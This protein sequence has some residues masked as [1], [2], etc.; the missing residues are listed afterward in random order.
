MTT[1]ATADQLPPL[2]EPLEII[3]PTLHKQALG[4][5]VEDRGIRDRYE[6]AEYGWQDG[7]DKVAECLPNEIYDADQMNAYALASLAASQAEIAMLRE[8]L[9]RVKY[10]AVCLADCQVIAIEALATITQ[11]AKA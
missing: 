3:W 1:Q 2:P 11:G 10:E 9:K 5:G 4:C 7:V 8:A 6:A